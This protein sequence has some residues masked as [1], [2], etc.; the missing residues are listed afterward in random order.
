VTYGVTSMSAPLRRV[1]VRTPVT[2][3]DFDGA[4][5][6][7][8]DPSLLLR[9]HAAFCELLS[10][11][12]CDVTVAPP[13]VGMVD[14]CYMY[15]SAFVIGDGA[16]VLRSA[17]PARADE[18]GPAAEALRA[19]GV[20]V[21]AALEGEA[22]ADGGDLFW[23]DD[24]TLV[25]GRGYRTNAAAHEQLR[26]ILAPRGVTLERVDLPHDRG[27][28]HVLHTMSFISPIAPD[29]AVVFEPLMPVP[30]VELLAERQIRTIPVEAG[31]Y[32]TMA[33]NV[34]AVRPGVVVAV[35]GNPRTR[36]AM[37]AAGAEVHVYDGSEISL[38]GDGGPTCL[39][40][41]LERR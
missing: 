6:R 39:T 26:T 24:G 17:K 41:P 4:G 25:A 33:C 21:V 19:A 35:D 30:L 18:H 34:L 1:L 3:G 22:R 36:R 37:E 20:P 29:L 5:W 9:Q 11:V 28:A 15:D 16:V 31:E 32:E 40:R 13:A 12:G 8:P 27:P 38:K 23:L 2:E 14:A 7:R 10:G